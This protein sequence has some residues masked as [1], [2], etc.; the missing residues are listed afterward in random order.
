[1]MR[2]GAV[3]NIVNSTHLPAPAAGRR[4]SKRDGLETSTEP[5]CNGPQPIPAKLRRASR[6]QL[7]PEGRGYTP[8]RGAGLHE[9]L[10]LDQGGVP[11]HHFQDRACELGEAQSQQSRGAERGTRIAALSVGYGCHISY[12]FACGKKW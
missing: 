2:G 12:G 3:L 4:L 11:Q 10:G 9:G 8:G 1:M 6:L 7:Q 5:P